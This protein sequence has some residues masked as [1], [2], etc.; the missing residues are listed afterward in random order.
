MVISWILNSLSKDIAGSML[1]SKS[2]K[3]IWKK[4]QAR[5]GQCNGVQLYQ[6]QKELSDAVQGASDIAG[7]FTK[8]KNIWD[9]L[10]AFNT[11]D[12]YTC[13]CSCDE[14][15]KTIKCRQDGRMIQFLMG[16]NDAYSDAK[17][18]ILM[19]ALCSL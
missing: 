13:K 17:V 7:H 12:H 5:F 9:E 16:L 8:V 11:F 14:K 1:Y 4:F 15:T 18:S 3:E 2:A 19:M 6:L 10:D